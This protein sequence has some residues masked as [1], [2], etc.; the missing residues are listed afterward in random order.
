MTEIAVK[1]IVLE[2]QANGPYESIE[3]FCRRADVN[4]L[5]RRALESL[6]K[7]GALEI[8]GPRGS[9]LNVT[10]QIMSN[11]QTESKIR[12][13]GQT[14]LFDRVGSGNQGTMMAIDMTGEDADPE[15]KDRWERDLIGVS[16]SHNPLRGACPVGCGR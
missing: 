15:E 11:A 16:L 8:L 4:A 3:D 13:S 5:N 1:P 6:I 7:A 2:R 12:N 10:D 14:S 9:M